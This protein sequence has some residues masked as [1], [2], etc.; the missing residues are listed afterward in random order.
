ME[1]NANSTKR[2][3]GTGTNGTRD[4]YGQGNYKINRGKNG[5]EAGSME[6]HTFPQ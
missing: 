5:E 1:G 3:N 2:H 4:N 6:S